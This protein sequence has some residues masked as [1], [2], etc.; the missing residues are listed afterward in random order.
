MQAH[1][2]LFA[3]ELKKY[4]VLVA[5]IKRNSE[6]QT[7]LLARIGNQNKV[8]CVLSYGADSAVQLPHKP[9]PA[10]KLFEQ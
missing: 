7:E 10:V 3:S 5:D 9:L 4:D 1:D 2:S 6:A 8:C